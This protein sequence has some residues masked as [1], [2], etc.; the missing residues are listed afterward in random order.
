MKSLVEASGSAHT[1]GVACSCC[2][3]AMAMLLGVLGLLLGLSKE[4]AAGSLVDWA[5][6][7]QHKLQ[8][9]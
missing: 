8:Q 3:L 5:A 9:Q 4:G 2:R 6:E 1:P 7:Q